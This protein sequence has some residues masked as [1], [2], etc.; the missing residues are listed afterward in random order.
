MSEVHHFLHADENDVLNPALLDNM[1]EG[2]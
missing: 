1:R 2:A